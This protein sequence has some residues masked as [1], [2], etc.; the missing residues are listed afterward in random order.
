[1]TNRSRCEG[2]PAMRID[3]SGL[4]V[5]V[6][7]LGVHG[8]GLSAARYAVDRGATVTVTDLRDKHTLRASVERLPGGCRTVF[9]THEDAD[10]SG[11]DLVIKNPAVP[12]T[13]R[14]LRLAPAVTT[15][16]ALFLAEWTGPDSSGEHGPLVAVTGTKG[17]SLTSSAVAH[18]LSARFPMTRLG[19]NITIS[20]LD[21]VDE[22]LPEDP[23]VLELSSFQLGDLA[24]AREHNAAMKTVPAGVPRSVYTPTVPAAAAIITNI[25][26]DHQ[27]YYHSMNAYVADKQEI[28]RHLAADGAFI[29]DADGTWTE[30][31][32]TDLQNRAG[33]PYRLFLVPRL[34]GGPDDGGGAP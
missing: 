27:D 22:I 14:V 19:G 21:F 25:F 13:A 18:I 10:F 16:I 17:K 15:D 9:G 1:M 23:V 2:L 24:F 30:T 34:S 20:P 32:V 6:M 29:T 7:G 5:T 3:L 33:A 11:A 26:T 31:F 28:Y 8:G 4:R 12:R